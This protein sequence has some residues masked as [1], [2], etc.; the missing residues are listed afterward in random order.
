[1]PDYYSLLVQKIREAESDSAKLRELV[2]EAARLALKRHVNVH[3]PAVSLQDGKRL[4]GDL[5]VAIERLES[6]SGGAV[7]RPSTTPAAH[8]VDAILASARTDRPQ[9]SQ[10]F[11]F[12]AAYEGKL[13]DQKANEIPPVE[14]PRSSDRA[15]FSN[16]ANHETPAAA[17]SDDDAHPDRVPRPNNRFATRRRDETGASTSPTSLR[18]ALDRGTF[19]TCGE[20]R[21]SVSS[22]MQ[23]RAVSRDWPH[24]GPANDRSGARELVLV[25]GHSVQA[26]HG[27]TY[28]VRPNEFP[29]RQ[30]EYYRDPPKA[31]NSRG[32]TMLVGA[33]IVSQVIV[34]ILAGAALYVAMWEPMWGRSAQPPVQD[35]AAAI[36]HLPA[37]VPPLIRSAA[38]PDVEPQPADTATAATGVIA[39]PAIA[40]APA[41]PRPT[42]YGIYAISNNRLIELE[43]VPTTPVDPRA[44]NSLQ[45]T[46]PSRTIIADPKLTFIAYRRDLTTSAPDKV[47]VRIAARV[48]RQMTFDPLGKTVTAPPPV[49]T[50][51]IRDQGY[52][53]RVSPLRESSE[54]VMLIRENEELAFPPGRYELLL[55]GQSYDFVIA[56]TITD[57]AQCVEGVA[58]ARGP[59]FYECRGP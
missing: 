16:L 36:P 53:L 47:P 28:F 50:W 44:R 43:Q 25:P 32:R 48:A 39:P 21:D 7:I 55:G 22:L 19:G 2:Y 38:R 23:G 14:A 8:N 26:S 5:E 54:M 40:P 20:V 1:M 42:A 51:L 13:D 10:E 17:Q 56:G 33:A 46:K 29:P 59:A 30:G 49:E 35:I 27:S 15:A 52:D 37:K 45:I 18:A 58:T 4:L 6:D 31:L 11:N 3:Y 34:V 57:P 12:R 24:D 41:F 9:V